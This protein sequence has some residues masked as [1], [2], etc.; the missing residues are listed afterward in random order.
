MEHTSWDSSF[1]LRLCMISVSE[2]VRDPFSG[3]DP[4]WL[5]EHQGWCS[6]CTFLIGSTP[7]HA[8]HSQNLLRGCKTVLQWP[9][10]TVKASALHSSSTHPALSTHNQAQQA[11]KVQASAEH[12]RG[13]SRGINPVPLPVMLAQANWIAWLSLA[14]LKDVIYIA[15]QGENW[16]GARLQSSCEYQLQGD[17]WNEKNVISISSQ[18]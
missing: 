18:R 5:A 1:G 15:I 14:L 7:H 4:P 11:P 13:L 10:K 3:Y 8:S 9:L 16:S 17:C 6:G 12:H 2:S